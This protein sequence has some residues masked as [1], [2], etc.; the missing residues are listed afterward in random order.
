M[1]EDP[2]MEVPEGFYKVYEKEQYYDYSLPDYLPISESKKIAVETL[3]TFIF[4]LFGLHF[5]E[6]RAFTTVVPKIK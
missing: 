4:D 5:L 1:G 2:T 3:D 6:A